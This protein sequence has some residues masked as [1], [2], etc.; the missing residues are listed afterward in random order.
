[1]Y[2]KTSET[3][4]DR[5]WVVTVVK[6]QGRIKLYKRPGKRAI[7]RWNRGVCVKLNMKERVQILTV[8][9]NCFSPCQYVYS[10]LMASDLKSRPQSEQLLSVK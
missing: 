9:R 3:L 10:N 8:I 2:D 4:Y 1:M 6:D 5:K 7:R